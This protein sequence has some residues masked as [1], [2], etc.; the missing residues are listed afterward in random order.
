MTAGGYLSLWLSSQK[1]LKTPGQPERPWLLPVTHSSPRHTG[2][3]PAA[4]PPHSSAWC[5]TAGLQWVWGLAA[6]TPSS[7][8][9]AGA[10]SEKEKVPNTQ[11]LA[12]HVPGAAVGMATSRQQRARLAPSQ[13]HLRGAL[14]PLIPLARASPPSAGGEQRQVCGLPGFAGRKLRVYRFWQVFGST[15]GSAAVAPGL[16]KLASAGAAGT[17]RRGSSWVVGCG[18]CEHRVKP[19]PS[20]SCSG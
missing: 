3:A 5:R 1:C 12:G 11:S 4:L 7:V 6:I 20:R 17:C 2:V 18:Q 8:E 14:T 10:F 13:Q 19:K 16:P 9:D 15:A